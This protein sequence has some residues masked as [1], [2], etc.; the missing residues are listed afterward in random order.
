VVLDH[1][2][3]HLHLGL[4]VIVARVRLLDLRDE[5]LRA[6]MLDLGLVVHVLVT[7]RGEKRRIEDLFFD[8]RVN[9][10]G[11]AD[12]YRKLLLPSREAGLFELC[13]QFLDFAM[14]RLQQRDRVL[15]RP[16]GRGPIYGSATRLLHV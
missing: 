12:L 8:L 9:L 5:F 1:F 10:E 6:G 15:G 3:Q 4:E 7:R 11:I 13:K 14:I 16:G 2:R